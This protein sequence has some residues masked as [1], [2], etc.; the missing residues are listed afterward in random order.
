MIGRTQ[1]AVVEHD[2]EV[3]EQ[4]SEQN[5]A[6]K[7]EIRRILDEIDNACDAKNWNKCR[8]FFKDEIKFDY[9]SLTGDEPGKMKTD[10]LIEAWKNTLFE[11][12]KSFHQRTNHRIKIDGDRAEAFSKLYAFNLLEEGKITGLWEVWGRSAHRLERTEKGWKVSGLA[13]DVIYRRG[14]EQVRTYVPE[15]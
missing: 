9:Q 14:D 6:D 1:L 11:A 12:K 2:E 7:M 8:S 13:L 10:E 3:Q 15:Q 4:T 5:M